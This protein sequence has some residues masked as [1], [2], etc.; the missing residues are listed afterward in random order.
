MNYDVVVIG[1]GAAGFFTAINLAKQ[2]QELSVVIVERGAQVLEKVKISGG[3]R[4]NVTHAIFEPKPLTENYPRG[5]RELLGPFHT[6]LSGDTITWFEE[7][8]VPLKIEDDGRMFPE[9]NSSQTI[10]DCFLEEAKIYNVDIKTKWPVINIENEGVN[11]KLQSKNEKLNC[12]VVVVATGSNP[13]MLSLLQNKGIA[14]TW[15]V[16]SLFTFNIKD[17]RINDLAGLS[18]LAEVSLEIPAELNAKKR[19]Y[20]N[21]NLK[22]I[23]GPVLITHW[24][25]SG[26]GILKLSA[27]GA[28]IL[29]ELDYKFNL[30]VNWLPDFKSEF[31]YEKLRD[32]KVEL[33]KQTLHKWSPF[34]LPKRLWQSL[35][36]A[37]GVNHEKK[38]ADITKIDIENLVKQLQ[39]GI[40][41]VDGKSTFKE[42]FVTAG[43]VNL[44]EIDFKTYQSKQHTNLYLVGEVLDIDAVTGGFNFQNA[45]T[46][47]FIAA[48]AIANSF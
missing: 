23:R 18:T 4:C 14:I 44:K 37:S 11:W 16:P 1:G 47:G 48:N 32:Y 34:D 33:A 19:A 3:G 46:G 29:N 25:M 21:Q 40:F 9:S 7:R 43:G 6:F 28:R 39:N 24:G 30:C 8:G 36:N 35:L 27:W 20:L 26:P 17:K 2:N 41:Q 38:W 42:E 45:W 12:K 22:Y 10:I 13:K 15:T 5:Q 31:L